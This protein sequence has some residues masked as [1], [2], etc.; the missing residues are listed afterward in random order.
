MGLF[1]LLAMSR[2]IFPAEDSFYH[3][4]EIKPNVFVWIGEDILTQEGDPKFNRAGNAGFIITPDG[5]VVVN[6]TNSPFNARSL[7]YEIRQ[8]TDLPVRYVINTGASPDVML[9]NESFVDFKPAIL[10]TP[11]AA[12]AMRNY[13]DKLPERIEDDWKFAA[14]MRGIHPT[15]PTQTF[16][17]GETTL[18]LS[19]QP[20]KLINFGD[21]TGPGDAAVFLPQSKVLFLGNIFENEY[22]PRIG[23]AN[24][25]NWIQTLRKVESWDVDLYI[26]GHGQPAGK[27]RVLEFR[28]FLEWLSG[29]VRAGL[30]KGKSLE[31]LQND[32]VPFRNIHWHAPELEP[33]AVAAV[34]RALARH[35]SQV[36]SPA[37]SASASQ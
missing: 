13:R 12:L 23:A 27:A 33:E 37:K 5:V 1:L 21:N 3:V 32:L 36:S 26:P 34:Y 22:I 19:G 28:H 31:Q 16:S 20:I 11:Q 29:Q 17:G 14:S 4:R 2:A 8:H 15:P 24:I 35:S 30:E 10:S 6:T 9:G 18:P 25:D 7:L